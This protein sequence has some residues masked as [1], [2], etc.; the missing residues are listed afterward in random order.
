MN[1]WLR[2][3]LR[4]RPREDAAGTPREDG[5]RA[6]ARDRGPGHRHRAPADA[7]HPPAPR[8]QRHTKAVRELGIAGAVLRAVERRAAGRPVRR[9]R[10]RAGA[11]LHISGPALNQAFITVSDGTVA[12]GAH[13][14]VVV[15]PV[16]LGCRSCGRVVT[17][18]RILAVC[19]GCGGTRLD[20]HSGDGLVLESVEFTES[21]RRHEPSA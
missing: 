1:A 16:R 15:E 6:P 14:D 17:S 2:R 12:D 13:L 20:L 3:H 8:D 9:A 5:A 10:V 11:L 21:E 4:R 7:G 19:S 18:D